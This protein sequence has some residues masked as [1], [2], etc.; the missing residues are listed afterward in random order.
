MRTDLEL[1]DFL[2]KVFA[3]ATFKWLLAIT[4]V[5]EFVGKNAEK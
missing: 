3:L 5:P 1:A 4:L 2:K